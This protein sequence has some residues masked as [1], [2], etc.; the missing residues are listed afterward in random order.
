MMP[1]RLAACMALIAFSLCLVVGAFSAGNS[2]S[3]VVLRAMAAMAGTFVIGLVLGL[4]GRRMLEENIRGEAEKLR[5]ST[6]L[7]PSDR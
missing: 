5:N 6:K 7:G 1:L 2:F 3:T 4:M